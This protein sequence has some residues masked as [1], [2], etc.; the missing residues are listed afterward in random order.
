MFA[1]EK[2]PNYMNK[3]QIVNEGKI[4]VD[5]LDRWVIKALIDMGEKYRRKIFA[6]RIIRRE[7]DLILTDAIVFYDLFKEYFEE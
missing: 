2:D 6:V 7:F 3:L 4:I 5:G 1:I